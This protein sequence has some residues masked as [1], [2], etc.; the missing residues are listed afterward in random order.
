M[1]EMKLIIEKFTY[2]EYIKYKP[3]FEKNWKI[4]DENNN[5]NYYAEL[6]EPKAKYER[7][8]SKSNIQEKQINQEHDKIFRTILDKKENAALIINKAI[9]TKIE[10]KDIEKYK[11][12]F[13]NKVFQNREA[14]IVYKMK[15]KNIFFLIEHQ[16]KID[17]SMPFRI[18]EYE[19]AIMKSAI[20]M[21]KIN[22]KDYKLPL[23]ISIV[24][25]TG[26]RKWNASKY[27]QKS[28]ET[29]RNIKEDVGKYNLIDV[30]NLTEK[31]LLED[32]T[33]ITKMMLIEKSKNTEETVETLEKVIE[34]TKEEDKDVLIRIIK[35]V[36]KEKL[37][38]DEVE[39]LVNK[40]EEGRGKE[41]LAVVDMIR[42][43]NQMYIDMGRKEGRK[44]GK[45]EGKIEG[46]IEGIK[47]K[48]IEIA[49][50]LLS[51]NTSK[52]EI[53][54]ITGLNEKEI[55]KILKETKN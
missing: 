33:F 41:V 50:K 8:S 13:V 21:N 11:N 30:N 40:I 39:R 42:R 52:K 26:N 15:D 36:F 23:V 20:D 2:K 44:E 3:I 34:R 45:K 43:E 5:Q 46:K 17:Y 53:I 28:Q 25:Y 31:E 32:D 18:L 47:E 6:Q 1:K 24:L 14:D 49:K 37:G 9:N 27:L 55:D 51:K 7:M 48:S 54:E 22:T 4:I 38:D 12:S 19:V 16:T 35:I 29:L 10:I